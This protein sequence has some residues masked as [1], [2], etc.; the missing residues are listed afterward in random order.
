MINQLLFKVEVQFNSRLLKLVQQARLKIIICGL[1]RGCGAYLIL[2]D[3]IADIIIQYMQLS[4]VFDACPNN[5]KYAI[6]DYGTF[7]HR[8]N[9]KKQCKQRNEHHMNDFLTSPIIF[10]MSKGFK[11]G[12]ALE[13]NVIKIRIYDQNSDLYGIVSNLNVC[14]DSDLARRSLKLLGRARHHRDLRYKQ[15]TYYKYLSQCEAGDIVTLK[16]DMNEWFMRFYVNDEIWGRDIDISEQDLY[17]PVIVTNN[18]C[19]YKLLI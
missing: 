7:I 17:Y 5:F 1:F 3:A 6:Q 12:S 2:P 16:V 4:R 14:N 15:G 8:E 18:A 19:K 9:P 11:R 10:G 13:D